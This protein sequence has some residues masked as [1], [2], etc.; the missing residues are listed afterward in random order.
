M[1]VDPP[2]EEP[3]DDNLEDPADFPPDDPIWD[4]FYAHPPKLPKDPLK[5]WEWEW[6]MAN[7]GSRLKSEAG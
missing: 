3:I 7:A 6:D 4:D 5:E 2:L 1:H